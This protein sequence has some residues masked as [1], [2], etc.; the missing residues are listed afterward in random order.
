MLA[1]IV[2]EKES[3]QLEVVA[4]ATGTKCFPSQKE[5][6]SDTIEDCHAESLLKR[7]FKRYLISQL[8]SNQGINWQKLYFFVSRMPCGVEERW[9]GASESLLQATQSTSGVRR[10][11]GR[12]I[13]TSK[14]SCIDKLAKW[15]LLG[16]Q[17]MRLLPRF[18][19]PVFFDYLIIGN[20]GQTGDFNEERLDCLI[21]CESNELGVDK[22][23]KKKKVIECSFCESFRHEEFVKTSEKRAASTSIVYWKD[24]KNFIKKFYILTIKIFY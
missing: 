19:C 18:S 21:N 12:G 10:K 9:E 22:L 5:T 8:K 7:A 15:N 20:C 13:P 24:G 11:P 2:I 16:L 14:T 6:A 17:G 3:C 4:L 23:F 1:A